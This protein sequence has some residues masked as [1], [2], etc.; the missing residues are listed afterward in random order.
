[1]VNVSVSLRQLFQIMEALVNIRLQLLDTLFTLVQ[2]IPQYL[3]M[4]KELCQL[5]L[6]M[7]NRILQHRIALGEGLIFRPLHRQLFCLAIVGAAIGHASRDSDK[8]SGGNGPFHHLMQ[9]GKLHS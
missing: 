9:I 5:L 4:T 6:V 8:D 7:L 3:L 2:H 1:M